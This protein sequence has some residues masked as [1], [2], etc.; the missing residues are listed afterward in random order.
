M[1]S[2]FGIGLPELILILLF[3]GLVMGPH[4]IR[5]IARMLGRI[6]AQLQRISREFARQLNAELDSVDSGEIKG[7]LRDVR[8]LQDEVEALRRE[9]SQVPR[10]LRETGE[11]VIAEGKAIVSEGEEAFKGVSSEKAA[12]SVSSDNVEVK[13][14]TGSS[15]EGAAKPQLPK[16]IEVPEDPES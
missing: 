7:A 8:S 16:A 12:K 9:L 1:D 11:S 3:A 15:A 13:T 4:R 5:Q 14:E 10:S 2:F 6:T